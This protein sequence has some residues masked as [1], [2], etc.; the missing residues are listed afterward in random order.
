MKKV[1]TISVLSVI[2]GI[3][4]ISCKP[5]LRFHSNKI[6]IY[7]PNSD[8]CVRGITQDR[9]NG[10]IMSFIYDITD[11]E[12]HCV[13]TCV[14]RTVHDYLYI[15]GADYNF[16]VAASNA[17]EYYI[18][19]NTVITI[20]KVKDDL[21]NHCKK[22]GTDRVFKAIKDQAPE[23]LICVSSID[24]QIVQGSYFME[25]N[26]AYQVCHGISIVLEE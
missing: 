16:Y 10:K 8:V 3:T 21:T 11:K 22:Y 26:N 6:C 7:A 5:E 18:C 23:N 25:Y 1:L 9:R 2:L 4:F 14:V 13:S 19:H 15:P 20:N 24:I 12:V 17:E